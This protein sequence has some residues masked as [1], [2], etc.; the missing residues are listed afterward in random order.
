MHDQLYPLSLA[1]CV[2]LI[3]ATASMYL[4]VCSISQCNS[5]PHGGLVQM[6]MRLLDRYKV[7]SSYR[8]N[9]A[10]LLDARI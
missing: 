5:H 7:L 10:D 2:E 6:A 4:A 8:L 1:R 9:L 3:P